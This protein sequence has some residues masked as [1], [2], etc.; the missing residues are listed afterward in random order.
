[1]HFNQRLLSSVTA[2]GGAALLAACAAPHHHNMGNMPPPPPPQGA[3]QGNPGYAAFGRVTNVEYLRGG[4]T[5]GVAGTVIGGAVGG[6]AGN[7]IG[8]GS[9]RALATVAGVVGGAL[10]GRS[11]EQNAN[12]NS[13][14]YYRVTVQFDN[15][16][17]RAF[18]YSQPPNVQIGDRVRAEG[19]QL[20][21]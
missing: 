5:N 15:G 21:R 20:Y 13:M 8:G 12:R 2:I 16:A 1:M 14:D 9:G 7:Q 6:L 19:E 11:I 18:D 3:W 10:I 17:V 4:Q